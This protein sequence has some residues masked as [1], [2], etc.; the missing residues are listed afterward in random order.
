MLLRADGETGCCQNIDLLEKNGTVLMV[1]FDFD[2]S[3][4]VNAR[5]AFPD[6]TLRIDRVTQRLYRGLC[7]DMALVGE[8]LATIRA[9]EPAI[10]SSLAGV[11][12]LD[13]KN[14]QTAQKFLD[15]FFAEAEDES[16]LLRKFE[17]SCV[18]GY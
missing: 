7:M 11:P 18:D 1:P 4:L 9:R 17:R 16:R 8:A 5:Y 3:G 12:K 15:R 13:E 10:R 14:A 2:L 6:R